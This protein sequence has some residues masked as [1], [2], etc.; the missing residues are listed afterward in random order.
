MIRDPS[1]G[2]IHE[3]KKVEIDSGL[4]MPKEKTDEI[5]RLEYWREWMKEWNRKKLE[6]G[7]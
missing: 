1:D 3:P 2:S 7:K 5:K 4:S 6:K